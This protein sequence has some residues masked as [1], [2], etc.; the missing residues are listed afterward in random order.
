MYKLLVASAA[1]CECGAEEQSVDH[2]V[3]QCPIHRPPF[4]L[5]GLTFLDDETIE[6]LLNVGPEIKCGLAVSERTDSNDETACGCVQNGF[7][8]KPTSLCSFLCVEKN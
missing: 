5:H 2:V 1:V 3:R 7:Q 4:E 8:S 6:F